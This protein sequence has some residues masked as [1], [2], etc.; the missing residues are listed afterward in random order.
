MG[1]INNHKSCPVIELHHSTH[2]FFIICNYILLCAA[3]SC[4]FLTPSLRLFPSLCGFF[5]I[6][7]HMFT[8]IAA[9]F[10]CSVALS[11]SNK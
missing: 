5:V 2:K 3:S 11:G 4:I 10:G 8:I 7:L 1:L 9:V 6:L